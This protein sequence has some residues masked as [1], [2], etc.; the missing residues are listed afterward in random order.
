V[1][2]EVLAKDVLDQLGTH[3]LD[4]LDPRG[5]PETDVPVRQGIP[6][7]DGLGPTEGLAMGVLAPREVPVMGDLVQQAPNRAR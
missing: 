5:V 3:R 2:R 1:P 7:M 4:D 6:P